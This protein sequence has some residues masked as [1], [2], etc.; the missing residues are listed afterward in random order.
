MTTPDVRPMRGLG[1]SRDSRCAYPCCR[2]QLRWG[3]E[4]MESASHEAWNAQISRGSEPLIAWTP[5]QNRHAMV[6]PRRALRCH[7]NESS[8]RIGHASQLGGTHRLEND[9]HSA[10]GASSRE[11]L[12][13]ACSRCWSIRN[14]LAPE[15]NQDV[16]PKYV[17]GDARGVFP[18][19]L[20]IPSKMEV[21]YLSKSH[22]TRTPP[23]LLQIS[24]VYL[25]KLAV[26]VD[27]GRDTRRGKYPP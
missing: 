4:Y 17:K 16:A 22:T 18:S 2:S 9:L 15:P 6:S 19:D 21:R 3:L 7:G 14:C 12:L 26:E 8:V 13:W 25:Q 27:P 20:S 1:H 11:Y 23:R 10:L 24:P 5:T